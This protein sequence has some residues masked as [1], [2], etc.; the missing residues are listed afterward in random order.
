M[1]IGVTCEVTSGMPG[2]TTMGPPTNGKGHPPPPP[3]PPPSRPPQAPQDQP[4]A[5][6]SGKSITENYN[7]SSIFGE[8][9]TVWNQNY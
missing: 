3:P 8:L 6:P 7:L 5:S 4:L 2:V 9:G 1:T